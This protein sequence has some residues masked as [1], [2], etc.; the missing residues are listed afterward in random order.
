MIRRILV[1]DGVHDCHYQVDAISLRISSTRHAVVRGPRL[2]LF[3]YFPVRT[4]AHQVDRDTG[5]NAGMG[6]SAFG[7][8]MICGRRRK[9][10]SGNWCILDHLVSTE[11]DVIL[12]CPE[13]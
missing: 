3:G 5:I 4:P 12:A 1:D 9:P 8:P 7:L 6:G 10:V 2:I 11:Y 13:Y